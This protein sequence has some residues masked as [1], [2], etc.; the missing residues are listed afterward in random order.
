[1]TALALFSTVAGAA[2]KAIQLTAFNTP[3]N[4]GMPG[5]VAR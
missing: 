2:K 5:T 3:E 1:V 4:S